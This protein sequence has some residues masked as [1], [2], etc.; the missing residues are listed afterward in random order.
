MSWYFAQWYTC[1]HDALAVGHC[2][3]QWFSYAGIVE[4]IPSTLGV[5]F[6][7]ALT[8]IVTII[9]LKEEQ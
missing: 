4:R 8:L 9:L 5:P 7:V 3:P 2:S 1:L 6:L